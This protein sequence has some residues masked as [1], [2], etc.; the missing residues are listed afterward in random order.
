L[1]IGD[2]VAVFSMQKALE[3]YE[4]QAGKPALTR[5]ERQQAFFDAIM[6]QAGELLNER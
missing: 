2:E 6:A 5:E 3:D 4:A 1:P